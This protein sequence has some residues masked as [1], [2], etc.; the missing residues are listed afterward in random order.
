MAQ[1]LNIPSFFLGQI[2]FDKKNGRFSATPWLEIIK[3]QMKNSRDREKYEIGQYQ[4]AHIK[5]LN[6]ILKW[7]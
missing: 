7:S 6:V 4:G 5:F 3:L 1:G 2:W